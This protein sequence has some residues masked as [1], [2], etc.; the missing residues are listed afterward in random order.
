MYIADF[1]SDAAALGQ[2]GW[3]ERNAATIIQPAVG[4]DTCLTTQGSSQIDLVVV[5]KCLVP[6]V[7][8]VNVQLEA[9]W[10][11]HA[12][13]EVKLKREAKANIIRVLVVPP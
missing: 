10:A 3:L 12:G 1:N 11:P 7:K 13:I 5:S 9:P 2:T 8:A 6:L 4:H